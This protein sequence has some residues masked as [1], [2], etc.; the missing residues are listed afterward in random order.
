MHNETKLYQIAYK[1]Q[2]SV[3]ESVSNYI[4][5][6]TMISNATGL[7]GLV[8]ANKIVDFGEMLRGMPVDSQIR[9][10]Y[11]SSGF[12]LWSAIGTVAALKRDVVRVENG[13]KKEISL[14]DYLLDTRNRRLKIGDAIFS[15]AGIS[16]PIGIAL[17]NLYFLNR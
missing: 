17:Y 4:S 1:L 7:F 6:G 12:A 9:I 10:A 3:R 2:S 13:G 5:E 15:V 16:I 14:E 8:L 11:I